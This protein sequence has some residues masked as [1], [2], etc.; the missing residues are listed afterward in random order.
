MTLPTIF[1]SFLSVS[2]LHDSGPSRSNVPWVRTVARVRPPV[3]SELFVNLL[4]PSRD[5]PLADAKSIDSALSL[6][7]A[8]RIGQR[9]AHFEMLLRKLE[10]I[11][12]NIT[13]G[14]YKGLTPVFNVAGDLARPG[15]DDHV[16]PGFFVM[17]IWICC[18]KLWST[19][20]NLFWS[21][22]GS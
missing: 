14:K 17:R 19:I 13:G 22:G 20:I 15:N 10:S 9:K 1:L 12:V 11:D 3:R 8:V 16:S 21:S 5:Y 18:I 7:Q 6:H 4:L 2:G